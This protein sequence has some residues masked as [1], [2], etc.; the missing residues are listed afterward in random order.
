MI[1]LIKDINAIQERLNKLARAETPLFFDGTNVGVGTGSSAL[2]A[3]FTISATAP[4]VRIKWTDTAQLGVLSF[5]ENTTSKGSLQQIA[6]LHATTARRD[7][8]ELVNATTSGSISLWTNSTQR[9]T[10][11]S[12]GSVGIGTTSPDKKLHIVSATAGDSTYMSSSAPSFDLGNNAVFASATMHGLLA[13]AT[14][15][16]NYGLSAGDVLVAAYGNSRGDLY[17]NSN[18][19]GTGTTDVI[20]QPS[21]GNVGISTTAPREI[22]DIG[23]GVLSTS[24]FRAEGYGTPPTGEGLELGYSGAVGFVTAYKRTDSTWKPVVIRGSTVS[25]RANNV[26]FLVGSDTAGTSLVTT[27]TA[28][29]T[30]AGVLAMYHRT[31]GTP[32][33][34]FGADINILLDS[35]T[36]ADRT[37]LNVRTIWATATDASRKARTTL[38]VSDTASRTALILEASGSAAMIGFLGAGAVVRQNITGTRTGTLAQLQT[39]VANLLTGLANLGLITDSTT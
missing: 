25:L 11:T 2:S 36:V 39:V 9:V 21:T 38:S 12:T 1:D 14:G 27:D 32:T 4:E 37:A 24:Y 18:Y 16:G 35:A 26:D 6:S 22:L 34:G 23:G 3:K 17:I 8:I 19:S 29:N 31:S 33:V 5:Y 28:T 15:A 30:S 10:V 20:L 7:N 13:L